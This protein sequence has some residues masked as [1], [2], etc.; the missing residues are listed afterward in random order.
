MA[1]PVQADRPAIAI[2][3]QGALWPSHDSRL[4]LH[5]EMLLSSPSACAVQTAM[6]FP[7]WV[8]PLDKSLP[9]LASAV[10]YA[11]AAA[12]VAQDQYSPQP[13]AAKGKSA[14][15]KKAD[16]K[17][18]TKVSSSC[19]VCQFG[20][21]HRSEYCCCTL[22]TGFCTN[23]IVTH[24]DTAGHSSHVLYVIFCLDLQRTTVH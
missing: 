11:L 22:T 1:L 12:A 14:P 16:A 13:A 5:A 23:L 15:A 7:A 18:N 2:A 20:S 4:S 9:G 6:T 17:A 10:R 19:L 24:E 3:T 21:T 8:A